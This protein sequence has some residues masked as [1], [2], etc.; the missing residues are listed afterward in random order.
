MI[1][2]LRAHAMLLCLV[3]FGL[4]ACGSP[5]PDEQQI[6]DRIGVVVAAIQAKDAGPVLEH[7]EDDFLAQDQ[8]RATNIQG[9]LVYYG[10]RHQNLRVLPS[11]IQIVLDG[12]RADVQL[13]ALLTGADG[14][15]PEDGRVLK[16]DSEWVK[17][18]GEWRVRRMI[19]RDALLPPAPA[20]RVSDSVHRG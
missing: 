18:E 15:L 12:E 5:P 13:Y 10:R 4:S 8:L 7:L 9:L 17:R 20:A 2:R 6:R 1:T 14:L 11:H 19:W 3:W 16:V